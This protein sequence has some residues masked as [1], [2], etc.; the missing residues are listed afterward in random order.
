MAAVGGSDF[1]ARVQ[2]ERERERSKRRRDRVLMISIVELLTILV[3]VAMTFA[4]VTQN[5]AVI[6]QS[7]RTKYLSLHEKYKA[8]E[9]E[10]AAMREER[11][12]YKRIAESYARQIRRPELIGHP[13]ELEREARRREKL[14]GTARGFC[15]MPANALLRV[16]LQ[17]NGALRVEPGSWTADEA[18]RAA[19]LSGVQE[20]IRE[21]TMSPERFAGLG[22]VID[23]A[24]KGLSP[25]C[26]Y[27]VE[28]VREHA[29]LPLYLRQMN[30]VRA[31]FNVPTLQ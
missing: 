19:A 17:A 22:R 27:R 15:S 12:M 21:R 13:R 28:T 7:W 1:E 6:G 5:D 11:D 23:E 8:K 24:A 16:H 30:A 25:P 14:M 18:P 31:P 29:D 4:L 3:F 26:R 10:L 9:S 2:M 20:I